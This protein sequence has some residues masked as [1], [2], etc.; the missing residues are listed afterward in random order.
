MQHHEHSLKASLRPYC[1]PF[2]IYGGGKHIRL[3]LSA[4]AAFILAK[5]FLV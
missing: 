2:N 1:E 3:I 5:F 4:L